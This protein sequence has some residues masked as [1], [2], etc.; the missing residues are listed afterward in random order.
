M[1]PKQPKRKKRTQK[2]KGKAWRIKSVKAWA[3]VLRGGL[4]HPSKVCLSRSVAECWHNDTPGAPDYLIIP[5][6][7]VPIPRRTP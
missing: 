2:K 3:V 6:R 4:I 5:V 1:T 7:I